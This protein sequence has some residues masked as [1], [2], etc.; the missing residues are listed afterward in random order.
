[1]QKQSDWA[2][3]QADELLF[4]IKRT[5]NEKNQRELVAAKLREVE[6]AGALR[7]ATGG[8]ARAFAT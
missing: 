1:M 8:M 4:L 5:G 2:E 6:T 7:G 3:R